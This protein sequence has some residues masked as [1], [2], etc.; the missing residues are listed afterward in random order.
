MRTSP[1]AVL[2]ACALC[3]GPTSAVRLQAHQAGRVSPGGCPNPPWLQSCT[4]FFI[5]LGSN[6]GVQVR[7]FYEPSKYPDA[8][9]LHVYDEY[10][11]GPSIR[12][13]PGNKTGICV[14]AFEPNP[15]H[16]DRLDRIER[17]YQAKG[18]NAHFYRCAV[19]DYDGTATFLSNPDDGHSDWGA[20]IK[21]ARQEDVF[22][23]PVINFQNFARSLPAGSVVA[24]LK[25]DIEGAEWNLLA[26]MIGDSDFCLSA[27]F[28]ATSI[29]AHEDGKGMKD[30]KKWHEKREFSAIQ[31]MWRG[32][33]CSGKNRTRL[34]HLEDE[35]YLWDV[36]E[37]FAK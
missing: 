3:L 23:V 32:Q 12:R 37:D 10:F 9:F 1:A 30:S 21:M 33:R 7:K 16:Y 17:A 6:L 4:K 19:A 27:K 18:W 8:H 24:F 28:K 2:L 13:Q 36:D 15:R 14:L 11:G 35:T 34:M 5:D 31:R 25:M 22:E 26:D 20:H 29:E